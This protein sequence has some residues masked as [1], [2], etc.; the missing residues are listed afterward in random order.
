VQHGLDRIPF[1]RVGDSEALA[2]GADQRARISQPAATHRIEDRAVELDAVL[3]H[4]NDARARGPQVGVVSEQQ[5]G[6]HG[7]S[8]KSQDLEFG[9]T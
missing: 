3:V 4:R 6:R 1:A 8:G 7:I 2:V 5:F 9:A